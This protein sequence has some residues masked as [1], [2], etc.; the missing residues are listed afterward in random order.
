VYIDINIHIKSK[1]KVMDDNH[2]KDF[3]K[4]E[5]AAMAKYKDEKDAESGKD[6]GDAPYFEWIKDHGAEFREEWEKT[7]S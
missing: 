7:H 1:G 3:I 5:V 6:L 4:D 2:Y